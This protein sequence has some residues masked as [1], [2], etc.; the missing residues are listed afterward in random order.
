MDNKRSSSNV[1]KISIVLWGLGIFLYFLLSPIPF[2][3]IIVI[4]RRLFAIGAGVIIVGGAAALG[5][6]LTR[7]LVSEADGSE[8][9]IFG[10]GLGLGII[11]A[12]VLLLAHISTDLLLVIFTACAI[13]LFVFR[14]E[15]GFSLSLSRDGFSRCVLAILL[16][17]FLFELSLC[18]LPPLDYDVVE[19]HLGAPA[20]YIRNG[21]MRFLPHNVYASFPA[22]VEM[23]YL[24]ALRI[25]GLP[26]AGAAVAKVTAIVPGP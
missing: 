7:A 6:R 15:I 11:S 16:A 3:F 5:A 22:N 19:Y 2:S 17:L 12:L 4:G 26:F 18:F 9:M 1:L 24:L 8:R 23:L 25:G 20:E 21:S 10:A 14:K 13:M